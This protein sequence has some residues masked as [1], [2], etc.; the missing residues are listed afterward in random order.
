MQGFGI[1][2]RRPRRQSSRRPYQSSRRR[3]RNGRVA[4]AVRACTGAQLYLGKMVPTITAAAE[5]VGSNA[6]YVRAAV[7][8]VKAENMTLLNSVLAGHIALLAAAQQAE[9]LANLVAAYRAASAQDLIMAGRTLDPEIVF[10]KM[11]EPA[12]A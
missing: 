7:V 5:A 11:I 1:G 10:T 2:R 6:K 9:Q 8:L 12:I 3:Y 4:A